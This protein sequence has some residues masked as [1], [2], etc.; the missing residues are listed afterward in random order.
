M[1]S[2]SPLQPQSFCEKEQV[3]LSNPSWSW[4]WSMALQWR[5]KCLISVSY[6]H[7]M[8]SLSFNPQ[9]NPQDSLWTLRLEGPIKKTLM[10]VFCSIWVCNLRAQMLCS[11]AFCILLVSQGCQRTPHFW[12]GKPLSFLGLSRCS[13]SAGSCWKIP[14]AEIGCEWEHM[15]SVTI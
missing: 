8:L 11:G 2:R 3:L 4:Y 1:I 12:Q 15:H 14:Q 10:L 7:L 9:V 13:C 6:S 5:W